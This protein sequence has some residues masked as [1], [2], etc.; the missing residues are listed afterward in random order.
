MKFGL[1]FA[2]QNP[3]DA[4][5]PWHEPYQD[6]LRCLPRAEELGYSSVSLFRTTSNP[7]ASVPRRSSRWPAR[8]Q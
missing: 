7:T 1:L 2:F 5:I 8:R 4:G 6:M 3:P